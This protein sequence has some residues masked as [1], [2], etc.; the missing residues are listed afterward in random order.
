MADILTQ[1]QIDEML[2]RVSSG[3]AAVET[4]VKETSKVKEYDF[5][6]PKKFTKEQIKTLDGIFE[7]YSRLVSLYFTSILRLYCRVSLMNIEEQRYYEYNNALPDY[8][9][10][11]IVDFDIDDEDIS[12][13]NIVIQL[14]NNVTFTMIDRLLG[15]KGTAE[16]TTSDFTDI[17]IN[18]M[19]TILT[20]MTKHLKE[21]WATYVE[22]NP[23]L[24]KIETNS[25]VA[26]QFGYDD[27]VI[28]V[29]LEIE[30][31]DMKSL[32]SL[33]IP[34]LSLDAIMKKFSIRYA[35][36]TTKKLDVHKEQE[37]R[38]T[39]M[40]GLKDTTMDI[41]ALLGEVKLDMHEVLNLRV[42]DIIPLNKNIN[43]DIQLNIGDQTWFNG[44]LGTLNNKKAVKI[45]NV[46]Q[47]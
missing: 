7:A 11:G 19:R 4:E 40:S 13:T 12:E 41:T 36:S 33:C 6:A 39:I 37:K 27:T 17:E 5:R 24:Q 21:P 25:R 26:Q 29:M 9:I 28:I 14:S 10:M 23:T 34:A 46:L 43:S 18:I 22:V 45:N 47:N 2:N 16:D 8:V 3:E 31:H 35:K 42:N 20:N 30:M 44:K 15:G 1:A 38:D 32:I